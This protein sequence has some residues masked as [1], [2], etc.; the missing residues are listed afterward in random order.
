MSISPQSSNV[1][2]DLT[3]PQKAAAFL[4]VLGKDAAVKVGEHFTKEELRIIVDAAEQLPSVNT[5]T[6]DTL[7]QEFD[8]NYL[9]IGLLVEPNELS[10][11][12]GGVDNSVAKSAK[13]D[14]T[15]AASSDPAVLIN[16]LDDE[17]VLEFFKS[18]PPMIS[19]LLLDAL[20][21]EKAAV[22]LNQL[23]SEL[24]NQ[25]FTGYMNR[26]EL[27]PAM[28]SM[29]AADLL[30][31][32]QAAEADDSAADAVEKAASMINFLPE[33]ISDDL[34]EFIKE[35]DPGLANSI[36]KALFR[37]PMIEFLDK[38]TRAKIMD[39][40]DSSDVAKALVD[41]SEALKDTILEVMSQ[42]N[43]RMIESE[44]ALGAKED[45][46]ET[47]RKSIA[48]HVLKLVKAGDIVLP[49]EDDEIA[50]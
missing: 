17:M 47:A 35:Q 5:N 32:V 9:S 28:E 8:E 13:N 4:M 15:A 44:L 43:R 22:V 29:L 42:R 14:A 20:G 10:S 26:K 12:L 19:A 24:R 18:E 39:G 41:A 40:V 2:S 48:S 7:V 23:D 49:S 38:P 36:T 6:V 30:E 11:V 45:E 16:N 33:N 31:L 37:F 27:S 34:V 46:I 3:G 21:Q 25:V 1:I 50:A